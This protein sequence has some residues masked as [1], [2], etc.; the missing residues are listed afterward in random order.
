MPRRYRH[1]ILPLGRSRACGSGM[2][3]TSR[4]AVRRWPSLQPSWTRRSLATLST[5]LLNSSRCTATSGS[6]LWGTH[7]RHSPVRTSFVPSDISSAA[8]HKAK[9]AQLGKS[10]QRSD[11]TRSPAGVPPP[12]RFTLDP[13]FTRVAGEEELSPGPCAYVCRRCRAPVF[14]SD[15]FADTSRVGWHA[16]GWPT[17]LAPSTPSALRLSTVLQRSVIAR[18]SD[19]PRD[20]P[21]SNISAGLTTPQ[22]TLDIAVPPNSVAQR[23]LAVEG[24]LVRKRGSTISLQETRT[25]R[26]TCL[27][28]ENH[29]ADPVLV[30]A[31]CSACD[32]PLCHVTQSAAVGTLYVST[33]ACIMAEAAGATRRE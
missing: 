5:I 23:G 30:L 31:V 19:T 28:D 12:T 17:F 7:P 21:V 3:R 20:G 4:N 32:T 6:G 1:M 22:R 9:G 11:T 29:R 8:V 2:L 16:S 15:C 14:H 10:P 18:L 27:R 13:P 26:E 24:D 33:A 25:W